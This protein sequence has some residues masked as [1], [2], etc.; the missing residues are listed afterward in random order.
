MSALIDTAQI[1]QMLGVTREYV[2]DK[3]TKRRDFPRP[4]VNVSSRLRRWSEA[5]VMAWMQRPKRAA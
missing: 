1:A 4:R 5:E 3:L 2:T